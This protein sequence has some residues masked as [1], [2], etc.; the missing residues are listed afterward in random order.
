VARDEDSIFDNLRPRKRRAVEDED[1]YDD[2][3]RRFQEVLFFQPEGPLRPRHSGHR[4]GG[5]GT[6]GAGPGPPPWPENSV[7][8]VI[9]GAGTVG[10][11]LSCTTGAW[12][13]SPTGYAYR[14]QRNGVNIA[15]ATSSTYTVAS[16]DAGT[17]ITCDVT[18]SNASGSTVAGSNAISVLGVPVNMTPPVIG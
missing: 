14:W 11:V 16:A 6:V 9:S 12:T 8:P 17:S 18:A 10:S 7:P 4:K 1:F 3:D 5:V 13:N 15:G 2:A